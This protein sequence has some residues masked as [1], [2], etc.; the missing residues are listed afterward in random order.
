M[1]T[2][3]KVKKA[4]LSKQALLEQKAYQRGIA[5]ERR[6]WKKKQAEEAEA[7]IAEAADIATPP[8]DVPLPY[9]LEQD[10]DRMLDLLDQLSKPDRMTKHQ[11]IDFGKAV[12]EEITSRVQ[13]VQHELVEK[14]FVSPGTA[15]VA[16]S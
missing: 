16:E 14:V 8:F 10:V 2:K 5:A 6:A 12:I 13:L 4:K 1:A 3:P 7:D 15:P 9:N 11:Y